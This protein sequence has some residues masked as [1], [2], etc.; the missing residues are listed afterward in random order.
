MSALLDCLAV[1]AGGALGSL[2]RYLVSLAPL[3]SVG[4]AGFPLATLLTNVVGAF[5]IG[6]IVATV[7]AGHEMDSRLVLFLKVGVC[8]GFT[9]FSTFA[10]EGVGLVQRG[11]PLVAVVYVMLSAGLGMGAV[12]L[13]QQAV[14]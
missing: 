2:A 13:A 11:E 3:K 6:L 14:A 9:T 10:L 7:A 8:G 1:C 12:I 5:A 4:D